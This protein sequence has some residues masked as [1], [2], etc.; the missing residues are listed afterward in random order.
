MVNVSLTKRPQLTEKKFVLEEAKET[1]RLNFSD[2][3]PVKLSVKLQDQEEAGR[4]VSLSVT[5]DGKSQE[6]VRLGPEKRSTTLEY[7]SGT[8]GMRIE[9]GDLKVNSGGSV[10]SE[11]QKC[12]QSG[13]TT[14]VEL[15][16]GDPDSNCDKKGSS[17]VD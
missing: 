17:A 14:H 7:N 1:L 16:I 15:V 2:S 8:R 3:R 13:G 9:L 12:N 5:V 11:D 4:N 6:P 10:K